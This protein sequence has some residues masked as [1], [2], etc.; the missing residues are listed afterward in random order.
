MIPRQRG[1]APLHTPHTQPEQR[2]G[3]VDEMAY[4]TPQVYPLQL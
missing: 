3:H 1:D 4:S 2:L